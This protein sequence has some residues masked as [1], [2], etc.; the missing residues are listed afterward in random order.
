[1]HTNLLA[2]VA[3]LRSALTTHDTIVRTVALLG[4]LLTLIDP[5]SLELVRRTHGAQA[6]GVF[7]FSIAVGSASLPPFFLSMIQMYVG[8]G[9]AS[10]E[11]FSLEAP[12]R[13]VYR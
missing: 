10:K 4:T 1:M 9:R 3:L 13:V 2:P 5:Y 7:F 11:L 8:Q 6:L 12:A